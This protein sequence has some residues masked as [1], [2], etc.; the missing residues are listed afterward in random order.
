MS[1]KAAQRRTAHD[2]VRDAGA[3]RA[4]THVARQARARGRRARGR[5][6]QAVVRDRAVRTPAHAHA[7]RSVGRRRRS[8]RVARGAGSKCPPWRAARSGGIELL[9]DQDRAAVVDADL[10]APAGMMR[11]VAHAAASAVCRF[12]VGPRVRERHVAGPGAHDALVSAR[13]R[14][15][16]LV[17]HAIGRADRID[18]RRAIARSAVLPAVPVLHDRRAGALRVAGVLVSDAVGAAHRIVG[19]RARACEQVRRICAA[20][21]R[22]NDER[23]DTERSGAAEGTKQASTAQR[24]E[25]HRGR[26]KHRAGHAGKTASR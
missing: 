20:A 2:A 9:A 26:R 17:G 18:R 16:V 21:G 12:R 22:E 3:R 7:A 14:A 4:R 8:A 1:G 6:V 11:A 10:A 5:E 25:V 15:R 13:R 19:R 23:E 24:G